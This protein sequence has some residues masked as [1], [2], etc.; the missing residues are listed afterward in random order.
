MEHI[1]LRCLKQSAVLSLIAQPMSI[2]PEMLIKAVSLVKTEKQTGGS[3][4]LARR[5]VAHLGSTE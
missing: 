4:F 2:T 3:A 1:E 5:G